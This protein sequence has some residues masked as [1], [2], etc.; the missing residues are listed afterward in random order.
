[1]IVDERITPEEA[2]ALM[3]ARILPKLP[4]VGT[5]RRLRLAKALK[6]L[7]T[8]FAELAQ[9]FA[10]EEAAAKGAQK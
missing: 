6:A 7:S 9:V 4:P 2:E 5:S 8:G 10:D 3:A 1:M